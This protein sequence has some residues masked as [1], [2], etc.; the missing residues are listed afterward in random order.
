MTALR[1][2]SVLSL[3]Q[4]SRP[5]QALLVI[6]GLVVA[7]GC[8]K[9]APEPE[10]PEALEQPVAAIQ[11]VTTPSLAMQQ[12]RAHVPSD[13]VPRLQLEAGRLLGQVKEARERWPSVEELTLAYYR[14]V[15]LLG[16]LARAED[17]A[18][19][20]IVSQRVKSVMAR[21]YQGRLRSEAGRVIEVT[22][23]EIEDYYNAHKDDYT[24]GGQFKI[25]H[26]FLNVVDDPSK[27]NEKESLARKALAEIKAGKPFEEVARKYSDAEDEK[28][29]VTGPL[30][31]GEISP[32][33]EK[34]ILAVKPSEVTDVVRSK[35][36]YNIFR[37][38]ENTP[39]TVQSLD[40]VRPAIQRRLEVE[41]LR[42]LYAQFDREIV[43]QY[44]VQIHEEV[45]RDYSNA[46]DDAKVAQ[47]DFLTITVGQ[48]R[49]RVGLLPPEER[50]DLEDL[51]DHIRFLNRWIAQE[52]IE[53]VAA[54]EGLTTDS[55][56][57][58]VESYLTQ[59]VLAEAYLERLLAR[60]PE[61]T[62]QEMREY[63]EK[64]PERFAITPRVR[65]R[66]LVISY[67]TPEGSSRRDVYLAR[68]KAE[69]QCEEIM[70]K[71]KA[72]ADFVELVR[73]YSTAPTAKKD[74]DTGYIDPRWRHNL[75]ARAVAEFEVGELTEP[76][77]FDDAFNIFRLE[78]RE[79]KQVSPFGLATKGRIRTILSRQKRAERAIQIRI[80]LAEAYRDGLSVEEIRRIVDEL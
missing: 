7:A 68:K 75:V 78:E 16:S 14:S 69:T 39:P 35:W 60:L 80:G 18:S 74:G 36:G 20:P 26:I 46:P 56:V 41:K 79:S 10:R 5:A 12:L 67:K 33:L 6:A 57:K 29:V 52:R 19:S 62:E 61:P 23:K 45:L 21:E 48:Y 47:S 11:A 27:E 65:L 42:N 25:R 71:L 59:R 64:N 49:Q 4:S 24:K 43:E 40:S 70:A 31:Y 63:Y 3:L 77:E 2:I 13:V 55:A 8:K 15:Q 32:E 28:D 1:T 34:A 30:S 38:E 76:I 44:P 51:G 73:Q 22:E 50:K 72:G 58:A 54:Q 17:L 66:E 37:L 9:T 53:H